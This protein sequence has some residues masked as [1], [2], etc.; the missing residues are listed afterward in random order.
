MAYSP[1]YSF[2]RFSMTRQF[3]IKKHDSLSVAGRPF[4]PMMRM[5]EYRT[6]AALHRCLT[7]LS[8]PALYAA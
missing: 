4:N 1:I 8:T 7:R 6:T 5:T 2:G 3:D